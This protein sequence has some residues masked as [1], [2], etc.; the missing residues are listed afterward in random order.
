MR[1]SLFFNILNR[2]YAK[3]KIKF[4]SLFPLSFIASVFE[5]LGLFLIIQ[6]SLLINSNNIKSGLL[7]GLAVALI[8][9]FKNIYMILFTFFMNHICADFSLSISSK[10]FKNI[11]LGDYVK[12]NSYSVDKKNAITK[13]V[14]IVVW[15]YVIQY[16][17][18]FC[19]LAIVVS[20]LAFLFIKFTTIALFSSV[21]IGVLS[22][23]EY[24]YL[25]NKSKIQDKKYNKI[26]NRLNYWLWLL[27]GYNK[28]IR[29]NSKEE[30]FLNSATKTYKDFAYLNKD[31]AVNSVLH[32]YF[33]EI[34]VML[35][36]IVVLA[37]LF[38]K[39]EVDNQYMLAALATICVV[40]LRITPATNRAQRA[41]YSINSAKKVALELLEFDS[42]F[43]LYDDSLLS[44]KRLQ[45]NSTIE[46]REVSYS[47]NA[48]CEMDNINLKI[49]KNDFIGIVGRSGCFKTTLAHIIAGLIKP[50]KGEILI[51]NVPLK[52]SKEWMNNISFLSQDFEILKEKSFDNVDMDLI[53]K[54]DLQDINQNPE[55]LSQGQKQ[56]LALA[57]ILSDDKEVL[58][59]DEI[60]SS[61]DV[62]SEDKIND[63]LAQIK[64]TRTIISI[65]H[66]LQILKNCDKII[67]MDKGKIV[68]ID[69]FKNLSEKYEDFKKIVEL[70]SF[71]P[72]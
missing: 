29:L 31:R 43:D 50:Q 65:A 24:I 53:K 35:A 49:N 11:L 67:Y 23:F 10:I 38:F 55:E 44:K 41:I 59:L 42:D 47:Y 15:D 32:I 64:G 72:D 58:I 63:I 37:I 66:R 69:T 34:S 16:V 1:L 21:F 40:I 60:T 3:N 5:Y 2:F 12:A 9:I 61:I 17:E 22:Y 13:K 45:F 25:K 30:Y 26:L 57:D 28:E 46:V 20:L 6:F 39:G 19:N 18:L 54:L 52:N 14:D 36:F 48:T 56:R 68:D 71:N 62:I 27:I 4:Y 8:Y 70:S 33:T 7:L 51:D